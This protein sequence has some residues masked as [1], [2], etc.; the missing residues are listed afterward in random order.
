MEF[1][2]VRTGKSNFSFIMLPHLHDV[3]VNSKHYYHARGGLLFPKDSFKLNEIDTYWV[4]QFENRLASQ[5]I[6]HQ[7]SFFGNPE[8][9][10]SGTL[11][12]SDLG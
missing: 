11:G 3:L 9:P 2:F 6:R 5:G 10:V 4:D 12:S 7:G 1:A 8:V